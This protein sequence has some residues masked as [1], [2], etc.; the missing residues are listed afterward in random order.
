MKKYFGTKLGFTLAEVLITLGIV[1]VVAAMT[2]P[3]LINYYKTKE[4]EVRF[5]E[6]DAIIQQAL[7]KTANEAGYDSISDLDIPGRSVT[8]DNLAKLKKEV[9]ET[10]NPIWL[11]QFTSIT[12]LSWSSIYWGGKRCH[13]MTGGVFNMFATCWFSYGNNKAYQLPNGLTITGL[14]A[15]YGGI[16]HPGLVYFLFDTNG[17]YQGPNRWG[18]DIFLYYSSPTYNTMCNPTIN[19]SG[20]QT[21]CYYWANKNQNPK[22]KTTPYWKILYKPLSYWQNN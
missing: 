22:D 17:P 2:I 15:Q 6:A 9:S 1:G 3:S 13:E 19:N 11:K 12:P 5:K 20:N 18:H 4:L 7:K 14:S 10:L 16:N 21:G 8:D